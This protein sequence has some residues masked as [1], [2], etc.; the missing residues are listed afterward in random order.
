M[1]VMEAGGIRFETIRAGNDNLFQ[2]S[3]FTMSLAALSGK[4]VELYKVTG[5]VG[6]ARACMV[7]D[8]GL[9][10]VRQQTASRD[11][12]ATVLPPGDTNALRKGY[13]EWKHQLEKHL[14]F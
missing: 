13:Q 10:E 2:A 12:L 8:K 7:P 6:A 9:E 4:P 11:Y 3:V 5:A 1:E 14:N